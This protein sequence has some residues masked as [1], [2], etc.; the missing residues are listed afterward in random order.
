MKLYDIK[1]S[2]V[3]RSVEACGVELKGENMWITLI[4]NASAKINSRVIEERSHLDGQL[5]IRKCLECY[6]LKM[7]KVA[8]ILQQ[9]PSILI[10]EFD[11]YWHI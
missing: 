10:S 2:K 4:Q 8:Y 1:I 7:E 6:S 9:I 3:K 5:I 11:N